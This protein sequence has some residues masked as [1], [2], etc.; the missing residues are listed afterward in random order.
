MPFVL[1]NL[2]YFYQIVKLQTQDIH[3]LLTG[4]TLIV[5]LLELEFTFWLGGLRQTMT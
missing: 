3:T 1:K 5:L 2:I 4:V